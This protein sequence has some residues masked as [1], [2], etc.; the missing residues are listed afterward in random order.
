MAVLQGVTELFPISSLGH[1]VILPAILHWAV[2]QKAAD[3]LAYLVVMHLGTAVALFIY[4]WRDW[5]AFLRSLISWSGERSAADRRILLLLVLAT[6]P[7]ALIGLLLRKKLGEAF[8]TPSIAAI[9]LIV[10]GIVLFVGDKIGGRSVGALEQLNWKGALAIGLAQATA[11]LPGISRS[12]ATIVGG[13][14]AGLQHK[15]AAR[16]SFLLATPIIL[17]AAI[18]EAPTLFRDSATLGG[19]AILSAIVAGVVA[20]ASTAFLMRYFRGHELEALNPFAYYCWA[21]G[22]LSLALIAFT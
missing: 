17:G 21:A 20:Y 19:A 18:K 8:E 15:E 12:G 4:F 3:W 22:A 14:V 10:N 6:I 16:F 9:F 1:A 7:A 11:L 5:L 13:V 2:D